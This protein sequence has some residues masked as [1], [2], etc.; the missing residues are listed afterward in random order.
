MFKCYD[1][2]SISIN[3]ANKQLRNCYIDD[4]LRNAFQDVCDRIDTFLEGDGIYG[5]NQSYS[6]D[7]DVD[8]NKMEI[9]IGIEFDSCEFKERDPMYTIMKISN[10]IMIKW[11]NDS[12]IRVEFRFP[13]IWRQ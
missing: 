8:I 2:A 7:A 3:A 13:G 1:I 6:C 10:N 12:T 9:V 4:D 5:C 11:I